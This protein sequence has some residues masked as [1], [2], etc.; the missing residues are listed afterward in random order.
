MPGASGLMMV[1]TANSAEIYGPHV[2]EGIATSVQ[3]NRSAIAMY[4]GC[5]AFV[6]HPS[7]GHLSVVVHPL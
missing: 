7:A 6:K 2:M 4:A 1:M 3:A 5:M